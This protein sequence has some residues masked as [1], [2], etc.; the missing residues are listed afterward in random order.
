MIKHPEILWIALALLISSPSVGQAEPKAGIF[1]GT[2]DTTLFSIYDETPDKVSQVVMARGLD[3]PVRGF[4]LRIFVNDSY[5]I[6][7][8]LL[9]P[10]AWAFGAG[11][12]QG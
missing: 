12:C 2:C 3:S 8:G 11:G 4:E 10:D 7:G 1:W 5:D 6:L 9:L